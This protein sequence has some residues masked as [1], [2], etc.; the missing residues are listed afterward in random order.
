MAN[1]PQ[2]SQEHIQWG[3]VVCSIKDV[4]KHQHNMQKNENK[5]LSYTICIN[6]KCLKELNIRSETIKLWEEN[7]GS[8]LLNTGLGSHFLA[9]TSKAKVTKAKVS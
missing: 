7:I 9:S 3:K 1:L 6:S 2:R 8:E 4:G 5:P